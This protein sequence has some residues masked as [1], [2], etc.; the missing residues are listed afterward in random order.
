LNEL[1]EAVLEDPEMNKREKL[2]EIA[3]GKC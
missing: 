1:F 2:L 3:K